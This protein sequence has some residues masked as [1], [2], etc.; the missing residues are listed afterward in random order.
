MRL[1]VLT[2][3]TAVVCSCNTAHSLAQPTL[4]YLEKQTYNF[5]Q[6]HFPLCSQWLE[7]TNCSHPVR[8]VQ[9]DHWDRF[10]AKE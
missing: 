3:L 8:T 4:P 1:K 10:M 9:Q 6:V 2:A 7:F 5:L